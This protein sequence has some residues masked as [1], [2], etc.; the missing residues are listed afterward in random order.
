MNLEE[1]KDKLYE[2]TS[3][4]FGKG[5]TIVWAEQINT[6]PKL[7]YVTLK[8]NGIKRN[9][10]LLQEDDGR[11]FYHCETTFEINLYTSGKKMTKG[12]KSTAN[13]ANTATSDLMDFFNFL[14]SEFGID[15][16]SENEM[17][18][19]LMRNVRDLTQ[20]E[21]ESKYRYRAMAEAV[22]SFM[23]EASG[24]Y[25]IKNTSSFPNS[26]GGGSQEQANTE[27]EQIETVLFEQE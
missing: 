2:L 20:L 15:F 9:V 8:T 18:I 13:Y 26:S 6:K 23:T 24:L 17:S 1:V 10:F 21:N 5:A 25:G 7:P 19:S 16:L 11:R 22:V 14:D 27:I 12:T 3:V 4:F